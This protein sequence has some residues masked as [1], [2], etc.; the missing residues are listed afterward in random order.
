V[1]DYGPTAAYLCFLFV[2]SK[3]VERVSETIDGSLE[4]ESLS[5]VLC[6]NVPNN[7]VCNRR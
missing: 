3:L 4:T 7:K 5:P 1:S 2:A 6:R